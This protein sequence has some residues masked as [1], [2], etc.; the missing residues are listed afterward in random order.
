[1][2]YLDSAVAL[3]ALIRQTN[4]AMLLKTEEFLKS[5]NRMLVETDKGSTQ[6]IMM[7]TFSNDFVNTALKDL[8][9][10]KAF[11]MTDLA[12]MI[13]EGKEIDYILY[14]GYHSAVDKG[15]VFYQ[16]IEKETPAPVGPLHFSNLE[17]NIFYTVDAPQAEESS[18]NAM[19]TDEV[20]EKGKEIV[21]FMGHMDEER[22]LYDIQRL[23]FDTV[24]N[25]TRHPKMQF[26]FIIHISRYGGSPSP[27][28]KEKVRE[29]E[30]FT[31]KHIYPEYP[32][33]VFRFAYEEDS[34][35][36]SHAQ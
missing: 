22:L 10:P 27:E 29:I 24:N 23:I 8:A 26:N 34:S 13:I 33:A 6:E 18:C 3:S 16:V 31:E 7:D 25:V 20:I 28:L 11:V 5:P 30:A 36:K 9:M 12:S 21:F 17:E 2:K 1:M 4:T 35:L 15:M 32:N 14:K 19:E